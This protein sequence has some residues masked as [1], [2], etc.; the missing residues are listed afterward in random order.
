MKT[1]VS[2]ILRKK[3]SEVY[4]IDSGASAFDAVSKMV[5]NGVGS[6]LVTEA[7]K[8]CGI[9]TERDFLKKVTYKNKNYHDVKIKEI[10]TKD[11]IVVSPDDT[12]EQCL[13]V[14]TEVRCR[15]LPVLEDGKLHGILSVGDL[16]KQ[17]SRDKEAHV[18]H[19]TDFI[20]GKY[21]G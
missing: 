11:V 7:D 15:H 21:P 8:I 18:S 4:S 6:L 16:A 3:G 1:K 12:A 9:V 10:M 13:A 5:E 20:T 17:I 2:A 19:L 14:M